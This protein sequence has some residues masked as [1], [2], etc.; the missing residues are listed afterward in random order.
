VNPGYNRIAVQ[1]LSGGSVRLSYAGLA[2]TNYALDRTFNLS[3][4]NWVPLATIPDGA[5]GALV[6]T[7]PPDATTNNFWRIRSVP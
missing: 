5:G 3:P 1:L 7:N 2:G 4:A 6:W